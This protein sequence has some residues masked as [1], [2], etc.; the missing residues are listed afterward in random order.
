MHPPNRVIFATCTHPRAVR[1]PASDD[2]APPRRGHDGLKMSTDDVLL[3]LG[4]VLA[5]EE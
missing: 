1:S 2:D 5:D 4:L 3:G